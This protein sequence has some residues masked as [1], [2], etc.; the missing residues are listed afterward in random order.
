MMVSTSDEFSE[1]E[2]KTIRHLSISHI[3]LFCVSILAVTDVHYRISDAELNCYDLCSAP[4][5]EKRE[6]PEEP[7]IPLPL[8]V[9]PM[10]NVTNKNGFWV[11]SLSRIQ[12]NELLAKC[13]EVHQYCTDESGVERG[14]Q[15]PPGPVG[16]PGPEGPR[17]LAGRSGLSGTP[18]HPG[19]VGPP[20]L[21]GRDSVCPKCPVADNYVTQYPRE[22]PRI[23]EMKCPADLSTDGEGAPRG[24]AAMI[25]Y[26]V[27][28]MLENET[29]TD[30]CVRICLN[31]FTWATE[32]E[33]IITTTEQAYIE[34][35]T[36][37]CF[38]NDLG[39]PVFHAHA[40]TYYGAWMRDAY[41]RTGSDSM[42]RWLTTHFQGDSI[43]EYQTEA[44][45]RREIVYKTHKLPYLIDGTNPVF[46][47]GSFYFH[48]AGTPKIVRY[49]L[50]TK[51]SSEVVI[52]ERAAHKADNYLF[53]KSM[54]Y[55]DLA[56][57]ENA[58]WVMFHYED[59]PFLSVAKLDIGNLTIYETWNLTLINH[60]QVSNGFVVCGVLY[61][62]DSTRE[63]KS[64]ITTAYD[65]YRSRYRKPHI[66]WI[67]LYRNANM[68]SYNPFD[69]RVYIYDHGYL[70]TM[71]ARVSWRAR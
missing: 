29:K 44:D 38:L 34:G 20:G 1:Y 65:F 18:G 42:K 51:K 49:E 46:F 11:Q 5:R 58:L 47:N 31:E 17:G 36:A 7:S 12:M 68:I 10:S 69:K 28:N 22:C 64:E 8:P 30:A 21:P 3:V 23:E 27:E 9:V 6:S 56:V 24:V 48:R 37:H 60:T 43:R 14:E 55:F 16:P 13:L 35:A 57:D 33:E 53:N 66:K 19:P 39:K 2:S 61:L 67:N 71:P 32:E 54:N 40:N 52:D 41:P 25:P 45:L 4:I 15:G 50:S 59:A 26:V 62:V 63:L 70:L